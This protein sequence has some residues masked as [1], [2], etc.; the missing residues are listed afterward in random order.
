MDL[1]QAL[2]KFER[3]KKSSNDYFVIGYRDRNGYH[4]LTSTYYKNLMEADCVRYEH[5]EG[6]SISLSLDTLKFG[7]TRKCD[8]VSI[9]LD[10]DQ[11]S[12][13]FP[14]LRLRERPSRKFHL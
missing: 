14:H 2:A 4:N 13:T 11:V 7:A 5:F 10:Y 6:S 1:R 12:I 9:E 8:A 3:E